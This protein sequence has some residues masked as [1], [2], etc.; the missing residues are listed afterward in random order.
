MT[1]PDKVAQRFATPQ[2]SVVHRPVDEGETKR[3]F[4]TTPKL[5][6]QKIEVEEVDIEIKQPYPDYHSFMH[7]WGSNR[8]ITVDMKITQKT[9]DWLNS[10]DENFELDI[11]LHKKRYSFKNLR[12]D[13]LNRELGNTEVR[14]I[15]SDYSLN[16][17]PEKIKIEREKVMLT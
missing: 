7:Y 13:H 2:P 12:I 5:G 8:H 1:E 15:G 4:I 17:K 9:I 14:L 16:A 6:K 11:R 10:M 3:I